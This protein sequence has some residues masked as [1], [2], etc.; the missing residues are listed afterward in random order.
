MVSAREEE[1]RVAAG[2]EQ[3]ERRS[4]IGAAVRDQSG[5]SR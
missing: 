5:S 1:Q 2:E 3:L 4:W